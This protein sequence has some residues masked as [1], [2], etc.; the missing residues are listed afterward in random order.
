MESLEDRLE[1]LIARGLY[2]AQSSEEFRYPVV[3]GLQDGQPVISP[4]ANGEEAD[5]IAI[6]LFD[7]S[8]SRVIWAKY[9]RRTIGSLL[10]KRKRRFIR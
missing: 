5:R 2:S 1:K 10:N 9:P 6:E 4:A 3:I 8:S 7:P